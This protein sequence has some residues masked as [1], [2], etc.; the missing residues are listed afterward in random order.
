MRL[1]HRITADAAAGLALVGAVA[2]LLATPYDGGSCRNVL[3]AYALPAT[4]LPEEHAP[5]TPAALADAQRAVTAADAELSELQGERANV[6][7]AQAEAQKAREAATEAESDVW[8]SAYSSDYSSST[9]S[10][11][12]DVDLAESKLESAEDWLKYVQD[13]AAD[14]SGWAFYDQADVD[15]SQA[16]VDDARAELAKAKRALAEAQSEDT[17]RESQAANAES[18]AEQLDAVADAAEKA[19]ADAAA[20]LSDRESR[21]EDRLYAARSRVGDL[22]AGHA[23]AVADWSHER[24]VAADEVTALN[25]VRASCRENGG[26]RAGV[27]LLDLLL[28]GAL[29]LRSWAPRLPQLR[30][31]LPWPRQ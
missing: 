22:E 28:V 10:A 26:W 21:A 16:E 13:S 27:A 9:Y 19:A 4:S 6:D 1:P 5:A 2:I 14:T 20:D 3:A 30:I 11:Q 25:N 15:N 18:T 8:D 12:L 29:V 23:I 31:R 24:R 17:A 7:H